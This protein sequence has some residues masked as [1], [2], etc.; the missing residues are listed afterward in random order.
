MVV[1]ANRVTNYQG[2]RIKSTKDEVGFI[3]FS[4]E[5]INSLEIEMV[6]TTTAAQYFDKVI[7][8]LKK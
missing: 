6:F 7:I 2:L 5:D 8:D 1:N 3:E 4:L